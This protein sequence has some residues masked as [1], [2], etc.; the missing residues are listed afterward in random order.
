LSALCAAITVITFHDDSVKWSGREPLSSC[1]SGCCKARCRKSGCCKSAFCKWGCRKI[2]NPEL[3]DSFVAVAELKSF[4]LAAQKLGLRQ[5][6]VSQHIKRLEQAVNRH[7]LVR[8][9]HGVTLNPDGDAL[10]D[11]ARHAIEANRRID[12]L[13]ASAKLNGR[14]RFGASEDF[15]ISGLPE[16]LAAFAERHD[17]VDIVLTVGLSGMLYDKFDAGELDVI[18]V[19]RRAGDVRGE[20]A[21]REQLVWIGRPGLIPAPGLPLPLILYPS[22]SITRALALTALKKSGRSWRVACTSGSLNGLFAAAHAGL[23]V[24][25]HSGRLLPSGL[26][27]FP[28]SENLPPLGDIEFVVIGAGRHNRTASALVDAILDITRNGASSPAA[29]FKESGAAPHRRRP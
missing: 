19:K 17:D 10:L 6:T 29:V 4:T 16:V 5:S 14:I 23:G 25:P 12:G 28:N 20:V 24:A 22:P 7:L 21:W 9:T 11:Y 18:F 26:A 27:V 13:F 3:L 8:D 2:V 1:I 15:V